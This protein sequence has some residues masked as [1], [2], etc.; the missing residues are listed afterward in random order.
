M[1]KELEVIEPNHVITCPL[2]FLSYATSIVVLN[3]RNKHCVFTPELTTGEGLHNNTMWIQY[4]ATDYL[5]CRHQHGNLSGTFTSKIYDKGASARRM[6]YVLTDM[7]VVGIGTTWDSQIPLTLTGAT[8]LTNGD[9]E[10]W[11]GDEPDD[12]TASN[13]DATE[14]AGQAGSAAK[15]TTSAN[16]GGYYQNIAV[17]AGSWYR[18][19]GYYK[20]D[21][22]DEFRIATY[23]NTNSKWIDPDTGCPEESA[24]VA[25]TAFSHLFQAPVGCASIRVYLW[26]TTNG[27]VIYVDELVIKKIDWENSTTWAN[28]GI[29]SNTW[30]DV[31]DVSAAPQE[32]GRAHV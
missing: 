5:K 26:G 17:T 22:G 16:L 8:L 24:T 31:F 20:N 19:D 4:D 3:A 9:F 23:D 10:N 6:A 7:T 18:L 29:E 28:I 25:W 12:W 27:D 13:A 1:N 30:G 2:P 11:A 14:V 15:I 32:I 21:A